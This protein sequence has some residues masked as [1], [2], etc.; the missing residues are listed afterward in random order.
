MEVY[1][2]VVAFVP[3]A[4]VRLMCGGSRQPSQT[5]RQIIARN[6]IMSEC[7]CIRRRC[8]FSEMMA[9]FTR[10][11]IFCVRHIG[12]GHLWHVWSVSVCEDSTTMHW[13][14]DDL[15]NA[16]LFVKRVLISII[17]GSF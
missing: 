12:G 7:S 6:V 8:P 2:H 9:C 17:T 3:I 10:L 1:V 15:F 4:Y 13:L 16:E 14:D 11:Q 5:L